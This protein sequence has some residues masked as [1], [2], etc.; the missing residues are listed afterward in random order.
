MKDKPVIKNIQ[1]DILTVLNKFP[2]SK[3]FVFQLLNKDTSLGNYH[4]YMKL[5]DPVFTPSDTLYV[6]TVPALQFFKLEGKLAYKELLIP[7]GTELIAITNKDFL[8]M[9]L[10]TAEL[11]KNKRNFYDSETVDNFI[12]LGLVNE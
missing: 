3:S 6:S 5:G 10:V 11:I 4:Y 7:R 12:A 8:D 2:E 1:E 9:L